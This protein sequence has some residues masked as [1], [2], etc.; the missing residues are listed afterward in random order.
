MHRRYR[1]PYPLGLA[2]AALLTG[3]FGAGELGRMRHEIER[4]SPQAQYRRVAEVTVGPMSLGFVKFLGAFVPNIAAERELLK[5]IERVK[6]GVYETD[7]A[8]S[9]LH[10]PDPARVLAD[11]EGWETLVKMRDG[12][13][14]V[15][16]LYR[17]DRDQVRQFYVVA[18]EAESLVLVQVTGSM[19]R[20]M[21]RVVAHASAVAKRQKGDDATLMDILQM[22]G[23]FQDEEGLPD[24]DRLRRFTGRHRTLADFWDVETEGLMLRYNRVE[25]TYLGWRWPTTPWRRGL[26]HY[27]QIGYGFNGGDPRWAFGLEKRRGR[28]TLGAVGYDRTATQDDWIIAAEEN[29]LA[30]LFFRRDLRDHYRLVGG[31]AYLRYAAGRDWGIEARISRQE[32][33]SLANAVDWGLFGPGLGRDRFR[34]N[35][36]VEE[37]RIDQAAFRLRYDTRDTPS[38]PTKG[39]L[40]DGTAEAGR[41]AGDFGRYILDVRRYQLLDRRSR[42]DLRLRAA[43]ATGRLPAQLAFDLGGFSTLRGYPYKA[44]SGDRM[45]LANAEYWIDSD[46][47]WGNGPF[48]G[49]NLGVFADAGA[50]WSGPADKAVWKKSAGLALD[51]EDIRVYLARP[52]D[53]AESRWRLSARLSRSF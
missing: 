36:A 33:S 20:L 1:A 24:E 28:W 25:G 7:R 32:H 18:S 14:A 31:D 10:L 17:T 46:A 45:V 5:E 39:W 30:A 50:A 22:E 43:G 49:I 44:F 35:P 42:L 12:G 51:M 4:Q 13:E 48:F 11:V 34:A 27:G 41:A 53:G 9:A 19:N 29:T 6:V 52:I 21:E 23:L 3:C 26:S 8:P 37:G 2:L 40:V 15:W 38:H 47:L 16:V